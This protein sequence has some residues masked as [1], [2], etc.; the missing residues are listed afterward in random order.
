MQLNKLKSL[1]AVLVSVLFCSFQALASDL[2]IHD[3]YVV[4]VIAEKSDYSEGI[5]VLKNKESQKSYTLRGGSKV[6]ETDSWTIDTIKRREVVA[7]NKDQAITLPYGLKNTEGY[8]AVKE[9]EPA[10]TQY[11]ENGEWASDEEVDYVTKVYKA[12]VDKNKKSIA[13]F[14]EKQKEDM[15]KR[16]AEIVDIAPGE[17]AGEE[18]LSEAN[19]PAED[20]YFQNEN[21]EL[22]SEYYEESNLEDEI[23]EELD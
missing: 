15:K 17:L 13:E 1:K 3:F 21:G 22:T 10:P 19:E 4:G 6:P 18:R 5:V 2:A 8:V 16:A 11:D 12:W 23:L 20:V 14:K 7:V 9:E